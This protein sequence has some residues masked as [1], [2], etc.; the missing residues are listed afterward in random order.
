MFEWLQIVGA[1]NSNDLLA[2]SPS[3]AGIDETASTDIH[4]RY[5]HQLCQPAFASLTHQ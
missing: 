2:K 5:A 3:L 1:V 4:I